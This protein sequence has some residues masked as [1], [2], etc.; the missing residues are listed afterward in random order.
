MLFVNSFFQGKEDQDGV[1][2]ELKEFAES[3]ASRNMTLLVIWTCALYIFGATPRNVYIIIKYC[4]ESS[5]RYHNFSLLTF[6]ILIFS[7]AI[8][9]FI[10]YSYNTVF[11]KI[12]KDYLKCNTKR[13]RESLKAFV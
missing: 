7:H 3:Q 8:N 4:L 13:H 5:F 10:Y 11:R 9:I 12:I 6:L 2:L 1:N